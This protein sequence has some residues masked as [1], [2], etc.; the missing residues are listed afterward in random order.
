MRFQADIWQKNSAKSLDK[1][2]DSAYNETGEQFGKPLYVWIDGVE[3]EMSELQEWIERK[4][5]YISAPEGPVPRGRVTVRLRPEPYYK[6]LR[7]AEACGITQTL[8][9]EEIAERALAD[10]WTGMGN[11]PVDR[12]QVRELIARLQ[13]KKKEEE[14]GG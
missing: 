9:L 1:S 7:I 8:C 6:L 4:S 13:K 12:N 5:T 11:E 14:A 2:A 3:R 10:V